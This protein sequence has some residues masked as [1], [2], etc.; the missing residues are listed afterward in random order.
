MV[1]PLFPSTRESTL[2]SMFSFF[3]MNDLVNESFRVSSPSVIKMR[4]D[5][6]NFLVWI[7]ETALVNGSLKSVP[8]LKNV[9]A[10]SIKSSVF[11]FPFSN[12]FTSVRVENKTKQKSLFCFAAMEA[13]PPRLERFLYNFYS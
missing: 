7:I 9:C 3:R 11:I 13:A 2:K 1:S 5:L 8:P 10:N 6:L 12:T 4:S